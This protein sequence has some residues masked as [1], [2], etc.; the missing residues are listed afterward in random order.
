LRSEIPASFYDS[1]NK[2]ADTRRAP[3]VGVGDA[4][5][6]IVDIT[7][8]TPS[9][10]Q[11]EYLALERRIRTRPPSQRTPV[12]PCP[13]V[14]QPRFR[15]PFFAGKS[16][17]DIIRVTEAEAGGAARRIGDCWEAGVVA[18]EPHFAISIILEVAFEGWAAA[19]IGEGGEAVYAVV[20]EGLGDASGNCD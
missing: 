1:T 2:S 15:I 5:R 6:P 8:P 4:Q 19:V 13:K 17:A 20:G 9:L 12:I 14:I 16:L 10:R 3:P 7:V 11:F 18:G